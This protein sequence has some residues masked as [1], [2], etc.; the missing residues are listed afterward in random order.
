MG[1]FAG[2]QIPIREGMFTLPDGPDEESR[3]IGS[4]CNSCGQRFFI[5]RKICEN[6]QSTKL[7][8][9]N[10][11]SQGKLYAFSVMYYP[12]PPPYQAPDPFV[13]FGVGWV[14]L[15]EGV[16]IYCQLTEND[17]QKLR[18]GMELKLIVS[19]FGRDEDGNDILVPMFA[20]LSDE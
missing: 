6:C 8:Q 15:P 10:L 7:E 18:T 2:N 20:P 11:S 17:P 19:T 12:P 4:Q 5:T 3:L 13:P 16:V 1:E 9:I 14:E